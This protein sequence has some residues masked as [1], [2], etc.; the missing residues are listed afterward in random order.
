VVDL[1][2]K[3]SDSVPYY[4]DFINRHTMH[5]MVEYMVYCETEDF[6]CGIVNECV[7]YPIFNLIASGE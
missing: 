7:L 6:I 1:Y 4:R 3:I 2:E 5:K